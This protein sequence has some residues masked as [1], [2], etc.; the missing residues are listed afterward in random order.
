MTTVSTVSPFRHPDAIDDLLTTVLRAGARR[1]LA[2]AIEAE[3]ET[4]LAAMKDERLGDGRARFV[5]QGHGPER[6][7]QTGIGPVPVTRSKVRD[8]GADDGDGGQRCL[9]LRDPAQVGASHDEPRCP[10]KSLAR[11]TV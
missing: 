10:V 3:A 6:T 8:R 7:I 11:M 2:E 5:R 4:F 9:H 1:L